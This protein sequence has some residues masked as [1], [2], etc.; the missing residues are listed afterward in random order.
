M[1]KIRNT[2]KMMLVLASLILTNCN[3]DFL[4]VSDEL[5]GQLTMTEIFENA[6]YTRNWHRNIF[7][8]IPNSSGMILDEGPLTNPWTGS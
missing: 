3:K 7:T 1:K 5:A 6:G 4:N 8:G 2:Y